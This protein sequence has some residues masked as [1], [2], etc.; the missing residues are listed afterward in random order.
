[1]AHLKHHT[2][3]L[4]CYEFS[5]QVFSCRLCLFYDNDQIGGKRATAPIA[6]HP[7]RELPDHTYRQR[8]SNKILPSSFLVLSAG[9]CP[10][11][12]N[13]DR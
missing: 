2:P 5:P 11:A 13:P 10:R 3:S 9:Y 7:E 8:I 4:R 6:A 1:V 12:A